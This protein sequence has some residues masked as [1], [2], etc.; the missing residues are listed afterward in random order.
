[1]KPGDLVVLRE[2]RKV[3]GLSAMQAQWVERNVVGRPMLVLRRISTG[4]E[5][6]LDGSTFFLNGEWTHL[7]DVV[8]RNWE[9][10]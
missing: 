2:G 9:E 10:K 4:F 8:G 7:M 3:V 1:V 5:Y 6:M